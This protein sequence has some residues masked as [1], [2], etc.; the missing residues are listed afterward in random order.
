[1]LE[2]RILGPVEVAGEAGP[3]SLGGQKQRALLGLLLLHAG[4]AVSADRI[5]DEL[6]G[7]HP[8][9]TATTSLQNFVSQ[10]RKLLGPEALVTKAPGYLLRVDPEQ[11]DA[12]RFERLIADARRAEPAE[13]TW[14]LRDALALWRGP[15]LADLAF[16]S[17]AQ[18]EIRRLEE[19]RLVALEE[20]INADL[21]QGQGPELVGEIEALVALQPHRERLRGHQMLALYRAGRQAEALQAYHDARRA[22]VDE[23][24]IEPS[25]SLQQ[26]YRSILRQESALAPASAPTATDDH[27]GDVVRALLAGRLVP[28]LGGDVNQLPEGNGFPGPTEIAAHLARCFGYPSEHSGDLARVA[29]YVALMQ[30]VG[31]LYDELHTLFDREAAAGPVHRGIAE[32]IALLRRQGAPCQ[33]IVTTNF[34]D[35]LEQ[36]LRDSGEVFDVVAYLALGAHRGKF[37]HV[38]PDGAAQLVEIPNA[39]GELSPERR[40]VILKI[41]G[42]I[43]RQPEREW[44]SFVVSEDDHIDY[45]AHADISSLIPVTVAAKL[46]RSHFLFLGYPLQQWSLRVFLHRIFGRDKVG[47]RSWAIG[48]QP[49]AVERELW[50]QRGIEIRAARVEQYLAQ[51]TERLAAEAM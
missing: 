44:E 51:L 14:K 10:L 50:S 11:V 27:L 34:D 19:L 23:L 32:L 6:W 41:H 40:T 3:I 2:Y 38:R 15:P 12:R 20:R 17:F 7:D 1:V 43:D 8:P 9:K 4:E 26:L 24:G 46:R 30:G 25:P 42:R 18:G 35:G 28:V 39:Y 49:D 16:E 31:P 13:R 29:E 5:V 33:L 21:E 37:L 22:L 47:Y 36:A 48:T 45:L